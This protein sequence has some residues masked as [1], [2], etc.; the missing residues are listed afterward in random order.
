M[1][2]K[3][4][5]SKVPG[6][7]GARV[8][9]FVVLLAVMGA[10]QPAPQVADLVLYNGHIITVDSTFSTAQAA[11]ITGTR[12]VAVG[13]NAEVRKLSGPRTRLIDL[14]GR[15]VIPGLMDN[16]LHGAGGGPGVD[17]SRAR[18]LG[19][20]LAALAARAKTTPAGEVIVSNSD[21]HEAQLK[22]QRLP[23]RDDLD[24][25]VP[26]HPVVLVRGGHEYI[27]NSSALKKWTVDEKTPE[28]RGGRITRYP[29]GRLNGELVDTAKSF[30]SLPRPAPRS[31]EQRIEDRIADYQK[32]HAAGLTTVR[33][34]GVSADE[35]RFLRAMHDRGLLTMRVH[36]LLRPGGTVEAVS[37]ALD[38]SG[39][40]PDE[41]DEWVRVSGIKLAVDGGFEGGLMR[42]AYEKPWDEGG[43]FRGLQT[44]DRDRFVEVVRE[45]NRRGWRVG[46]HAVG[47]AAIDLVLDA[48]EA[49][50]RERSIT[51][52]RWTIEHAFIGRPDHLPRLKALDVAIS[53][54][55]HLY[56]AGPSLV[57]YWG[58]DRA[59]LT[60]PVRRYLDAGL[61]V[62]SG[63]DAA[64]VP[65]PPLWTI[66]HFVTRDTMTGGVMGRDQRISRKEALQLATI[67]NARL[68]FDE[69]DK[70]SIEVGKLADLVVVSED[71]LTCPEPRIRD[72]KV[73][74]TM[75]GGRIV[76]RDQASGIR[77]QIPGS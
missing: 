17:L 6:F 58:L 66:Y 57:K 39:L 49:A 33:H 11:A 43:S 5:G 77:D 55:N 10:G 45:L 13:T 9:G 46:T 52:R 76:F 8:P 65:Y 30:V 67:N 41:G 4:K 62:S 51:G 68:M 38:E 74:M 2:P 75:V 28:P 54:Q 69:K 14:G 3:M 70:G 40:K 73:M 60:T 61:L 23:L 44:V 1:L 32:L 64:V 24:A 42:A 16:H 37:R 35:Y 20:V 48:Y 31:P 22:E 63:T 19:D 21:W 25:V 29:D 59:A 26:N 12:F 15:T 36:A 56:L 27:L 47:D 72:A 18:S 53:A 71:L 50:H 7:Q 34:P